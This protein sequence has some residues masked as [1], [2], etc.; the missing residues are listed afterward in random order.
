MEGK[1]RILKGGFLDLGYKAAVGLVP[2]KDHTVITY[3]HKTKKQQDLRMT[4][5]APLKDG[6]LCKF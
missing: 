2:L 6:N 5:Y 4:M 1:G 3:H